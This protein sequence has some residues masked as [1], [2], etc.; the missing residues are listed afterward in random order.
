MRRPQLSISAIAIAAMWVAACATTKPTPKVV[1]PAEQPDVLKPQTSFPSQAELTSLLQ[2]T[3]EVPPLVLPDVDDHARFAVSALP[4]EAGH[5]ASPT[6]RAQKLAQE[7]VPS[8]QLTE[9]GQ[10]L[11]RHA[12]A[13][14]GKKPATTLT[15]RTTQFLMGLCG[16]QAPTAN[17][18]SFGGKVPA[19]VPDDE[20]FKQWA[21]DFQKFMKSANLTSRD[22]VGL[23]FTRIGDHAEF[24]AV[25]MRP[26]ATLQV[27][28][29]AAD[30]AGDVHI[31]GEVLP[32]A[33]VARLKE[34]VMLVNK[35]AYE[36]AYCRMDDV[37]LPRFSAH[38]PVDVNDDLA[39]LEGV[40]LEEGRVMSTVF[41]RTMLR[42]SGKEVT[43]FSP[44]QYVAELPDDDGRGVNALFVE[45]VNQVR[46][47]LSR[48]ALSFQPKQSDVFNK[49]AGPFFHDVLLG[50]LDKNVADKLTL[51][52]LAGWDVEGAAI[53]S[54]EIS[55]VYGFGLQASP[56]QLVNRSLSMPTARRVLLNPDTNTMAVGTVQDAKSKM[57]AVVFAGWAT[58]GERDVDD[59]RAQIEKSLLAARGDG[60][61]SVGKLARA[62][63][64]MTEAAQRL[65]AGE[66][67]DV[68]VQSSIN[69]AAQAEQQ[70]LHGQVF[71]VRDFKDIPWPAKFKNAK[72][73][74]MGVGVAVYKPDGASWSVYVVFIAAKLPQGMVAMR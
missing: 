32:A 57:S 69:R 37:P 9:A 74:D 62:E 49:A 14:K 35:G 59:E 44:F 66:H 2:A 47:K 73:V 68:I 16:A 13:L 17:F 28:K 55:W 33:G 71:V 11:V 4:M 39:E 18:M 34:V 61:G 10:C 56:A 29:R 42:P 20:I 30:D 3:E 1:T 6:T 46:A 43:E 26:L 19:K 12:M 72:S 41:M 27:Y 63:R 58:F 65:E 23:T 70:N 21:G 25:R 53:R 45:G 38:C 7:A 31:E 64:V 24:L 48:S 40:L 50:K 67:L 54:G 52:L 51:G 15:K 60:S 8:L 36:V 5:K 22:E